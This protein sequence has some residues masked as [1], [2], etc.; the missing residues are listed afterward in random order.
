MVRSVLLGVGQM[1]LM[2]AL[3]ATTPA[4]AQT[5]DPDRLNTLT[6]ELASD[7]FEGRGPV[8]VG[9]DRTIE[10]LV[11]QFSALG[12][13]P[14]GKDGSWVQVAQVS[15]TMQDGPATL[16][17]R[18]GD[19][20]LSFERAKDIIVGS[21]RPVDRITLDNV[22]VVFAGYGV[23]AP[24]RGWDDF[25][26]VDVTGKIIL[27]IVNDPDFGAPEDHPVANRFDGRAMTFYGRWPYKFQEAAAQ[28][29]AGV[30]VIHDTAGAGYPWSTL[31][32]SRQHRISILCVPIR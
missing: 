6:R 23:S 32:A 27:V 2:A 19:Q 26:D 8:T 12:L 29:A 4:M 7:H 3:V 20:S 9:E 18:A 13:E 25:K 30:L 17:A 22:P 24:E 5:I 31:E 14:G 21:D 15:R 16:R 1:A 28:G 11:Q 10:W